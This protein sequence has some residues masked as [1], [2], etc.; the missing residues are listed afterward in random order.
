VSLSP[1]T[2]L[3]GSNNARDRQADLVGGNYIES[4]GVADPTTGVRAQ[5]VSPAD[6]ET[7]GTSVYGILV[8]AVGK[9]KNVLGTGFDTIVNAGAD[10]MQPSGVQAM[11]AMLAKESTATSTTSITSTTVGMTISV[12]AT[13]GFIPGERINLEPGTAS[14]ESARIASVVTNT[15][16]SITFPTG[17][18]VFSHT[19]PFAIQAFQENMPRQAPGTTGVALVSSDGVKPAYRFSVQGITPVA[20]PTDVLQIR[21]SSTMT[22]RVRRVKIGG[23]AGTAGGMAC[24]LIRRSTAGTVGSATI[25]SITAEQHDK[26]DAAPTCTVGYVQTANYGTPGSSAGVADSGRVFLNTS[27]AGPTTEVVWEFPSTGPKAQI[28]RGTS[29]YLWVNFAGA[30]VPSSGV[31][32]FTVVLEEDG[33]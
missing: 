6:N 11:S 3:D 21:G 23:L 30:T 22:G 16:I 13:A 1:F 33:S 5:V 24:Q 2:F 25:T 15:S 10:L 4:V 12:A 7:V 9:L 31:L 28:L 19:Q 17:G 26:S 27:T 8:R 14:Y 32:D 20:T 18:A 29:D